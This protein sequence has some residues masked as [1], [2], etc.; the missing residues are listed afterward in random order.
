MYGTSFGAR[1][2]GMPGGGGMRG[3]PMRGSP[4][5]AGGMGPG[6]AAA[7][8]ASVLRGSPLGGGMPSGS[9]LPATAQ[10]GP[11]MPGAGGMGVNPYA[12]GAPMRGS[13]LGGGAAAPPGAAPAMHPGGHPGHPGIR[14][15][16]GRFFR[17]GGSGFPWSWYGAGYW[18]GGCYYAWNGVSY[19]PVCPQSAYAYTPQLA[20]PSFAGVSPSHTTPR[21][22]MHWQRWGTPPHGYGF[23]PDV[24]FLPDAERQG[25]RVSFTPSF[26]R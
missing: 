1:G 23:V 20:V 5:G 2:G 6:L 13:P 18:Y 3:A 21:H 4:L 19:E 9:S 7:R 11:F 22:S 10:H 26:L 14:G 15:R 8:G 16:G 25:P 17:G 12:R 24:L